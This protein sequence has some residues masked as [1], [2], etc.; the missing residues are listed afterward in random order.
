MGSYSSIYLSLSNVVLYTFYPH[1][2]FSYII[3]LLGTSIYDVET[4]KSNC[5]NQEDIKQALGRDF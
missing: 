5:V 1:H 2:K 3:F 4:T